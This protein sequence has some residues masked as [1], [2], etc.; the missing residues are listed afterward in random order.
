[1]P[2]EFELHR[3][4][5]LLEKALLLE[6]KGDYGHAAEFFERIL[7]N[8]EKRPIS[9][10]GGLEEIEILHH[11]ARLY[12]NLGRF[13][14]AEALYKKSLAHRYKDASHPYGTVATL[15]LLAEVQGA[16]DRVSEQEETLKEAIGLARDMDSHSMVDLLNE[17]GWLYTG[18]G[19]LGD[20]ESLF[21]QSLKISQSTRPD[22]DPHIEGQGFLLAAQG[23]LKEAEDLFTLSLK[24]QERTTSKYVSPQLLNNLGS[25]YLA[26]GRLDDAEKILARC[27]EGERGYADRPEFLTSSCHA[28]LGDVYMK[29][30][31]YSLAEPLLKLA[32]SISR[33]YSPNGLSTARALSGLGALYLSQGS[34]PE[35]IHS[36]DRLEA[37]IQRYEGS[38]G[39][40]G[41]RDVPDFLLHLLSIY[42][43]HQALHPQ[44]LYTLQRLTRSQG[45]RM[46]RE[47]PLQPRELRASQLTAMPNAVA[48]TFALLDKDPDAIELAFETRLNRQ[49]LL[50][51]I[52]RR[53]QLV[54]LSSP[55]TRERVD[56]IAYIDRKLASVSLPSMRRSALEEERE[57]LEAELYKALPELRIEPVTIAQVAA[58]LPRDGL[59]VEIQKYSPY[60]GFQ[61]GNIV[62]GEPRYVAL[63]L[64]ADGQSARV[65]L[66]PAKPIDEA[67]GKALAVTEGKNED[68]LPLWSKVSSL[69]LDPLQPHFGGIGQLFLSPEGALHQVPFAALPSARDSRRLF[70]HAVR[71]RIITTGRDLVRLQKSA[72]AG[73]A[74][75]VIAHPLYSVTGRTDRPCTS[76][77]SAVSA[78]SPL[79]GVGQRGRQERSGALGPGI[80]WCPLPATEKEAQQVAKL[81]SAGAPIIQEN[82]TAALALR[83]KGPRIFHIATHGFFLPEQPHLPV[84]NPML[85]GAEFASV[86]AAQENPMLRSGLVMA[87][88]NHPD[89]NPADDGYLTAAEVT[90]MD[91]NGT[92]L[93]TLSACQTGLGDVRSGEGVYGLQRALSVAG[94]RTTLLS[95]W[96]V[97]D[98]ATAYFMQRYYRLVTQGKGR[99]EALMAVQQEFL[100]DPPRKEWSDYRF[101]AAWQLTGDTTPLPAR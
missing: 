72:G 77:A 20:A 87:G 65:R 92:E 35:A 68:P 40:G 14:E 8:H 96:K 12:R 17:L 84:P 52:E 32:L 34:L 38:N 56:R 6:R 36:F 24:K 26:Q 57:R 100:S 41:H 46:R 30:G 49:G 69:V 22:E 74:P 78:P 16:Q 37:I 93:V 19:R 89:W 83:Q 9:T 25:V 90:G 86:I 50:A 47:L 53:Q 3:Q 10:Q 15:Q 51:E 81:L 18:I 76:V 63:L 85:A 66:G 42:Q 48:T 28:G 75:V 54:A 33:K 61:K 31:K 2:H 95:L 91:L 55:A 23:R 58:A 45:N 64:K 59:L 44:A 70:S 60:L 79:V 88:A 11:L 62:W 39:V 98:E 97:D 43:I 13:M 21:R 1:M 73:G 5:D 67:V 82:A 99:M 80:V 7:E 101:W 4:A 29:Q 71:L 94:A 27:W